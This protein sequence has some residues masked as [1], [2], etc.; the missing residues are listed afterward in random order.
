L[1]ADADLRKRVG[2]AARDRILQKFDFSN[3]VR[4]M[5]SFYEQLMHSQ[6]GRSP[7]SIPPNTR[8]G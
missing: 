2:S 8:K 6:N 7:A 3:R 1:L 4:W 5:E